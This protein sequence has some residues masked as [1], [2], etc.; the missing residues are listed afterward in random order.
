MDATWDRDWEHLTGWK[1]RLVVAGAV[2]PSFSD[3]DLLAQQIGVDLGSEL[4]GSRS[5][6]ITRRYVRAF[7]DL[8]LGGRPQPLLDGPSA[9]YPEV[10]FCSPETKTCT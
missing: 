5:V 1:R 10:G 8:H 3:Y 9:R 4:A 2:H 6:D 7:F